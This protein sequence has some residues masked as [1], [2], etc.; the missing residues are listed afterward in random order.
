MYP[1]HHRLRLTLTAVTLAGL[2]IVATGVGLRAETPPPSPTCST[3]PNP[4][5]RPSSATP[6]ASATPLRVNNVLASYS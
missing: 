6:P 2:A 3:T 1:P 4:T 5:A